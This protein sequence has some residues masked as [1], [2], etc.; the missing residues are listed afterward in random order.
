MSADDP[1]Y[2]GVAERYRLAARLRQAGHANQARNE[3][4][5]QEMITLADALM[6]GER[7]EAVGSWL[8]DYMDDVPVTGERY[9]GFSEHVAVEPDGT[10]TRWSSAD[11]LAVEGDAPPSERERTIAQNERIRAER[12]LA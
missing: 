2:V 5:R 10:V 8:L 1:T 9:A 3:A 12:E 11:L 7:V 4:R 6:R